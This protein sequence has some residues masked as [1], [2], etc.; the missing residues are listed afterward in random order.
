MC[1]LHSLLFG[2]VSEGN[3]AAAE[4]Q[5]PLLI[6]APDAARDICLSLIQPLT[7]V[8]ILYIHRRE[9]SM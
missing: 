1:K 6:I 5:P 9:R 3:R 4:V 2:G 8:T 7:S